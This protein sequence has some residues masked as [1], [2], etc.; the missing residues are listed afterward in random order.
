[1]HSDVSNTMLITINQHT[2]NNCSAHNNLK[3]NSVM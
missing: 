2:W 3:S 1:M